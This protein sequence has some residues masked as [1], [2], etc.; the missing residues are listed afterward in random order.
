MFNLT[1]EQLVEKIISPLFVLVEIIAPQQ[2]RM[3][4]KQAGL[5]RLVFLLQLYKTKRMYNVSH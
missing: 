5:C 4:D 2:Y 3:S 1:V